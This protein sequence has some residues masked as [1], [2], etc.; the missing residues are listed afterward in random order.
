MIKAS[1]G[2]GRKARAGESS[3]LFSETRDGQL[4]NVA[5]YVRLSRELQV[6]ALKAEVIKNCNTSEILQ[7]HPNGKK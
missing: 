4:C 2:R 3:L 1:S 6:R 5:D 7:S